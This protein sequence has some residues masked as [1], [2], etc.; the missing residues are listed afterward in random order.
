[1]FASK[2]KFSACKTHLD[3]E[4]ECSGFFPLKQNKNCMINKS[5]HRTECHLTD[6]INGSIE[7]MQSR[8]S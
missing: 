4:L 8:V 7:N 3:S 1:M 2:K 6:I 5:I